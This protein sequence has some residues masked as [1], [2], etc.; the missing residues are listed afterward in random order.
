MSFFLLFR[1]GQVTALSPSSGGFGGGVPITV[2]GRGFAALP[3]GATSVSVC[4][5]PCTLTAS[6]YSSITCTT[7]AIVTPT[8]LTAFANALPV[9]LNGTAIGLGRTS[10]YYRYATDGNIE[11]TMKAA[12][13][14]AGALC[15]SVGIDLGAAS[16]GRV[17]KVRVYPNFRKASALAGATF[18]GSSDG[19]TYE[20]LATVT[21]RVQE[22]WTDV[23]VTSVHNFRFLRYVSPA[24]GLCEVC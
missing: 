21:G 9:V 19:T 12:S 20:T 1:V 5:V 17:V 3:S 8:S 11:T 23:E 14:A 15:C 13:C 16:V 7:P 18:Q 6:T 2:T 4:G 24:S 22:S 10:Q